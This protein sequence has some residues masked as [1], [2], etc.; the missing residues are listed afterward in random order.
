ME[1]RFDGKIALVTGAGKG[2]FIINNFKT[3]YDHHF[4]NPLASTTTTPFTET[5]VHLLNNSETS[6]IM[7]ISQ[8]HL[9]CSNCTISEHY[10]LY[11]VSQ[12]DFRD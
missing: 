12:F 4:S 10:V 8:G 1:F 9:E 5:N 6:S 11:F 3:V 2:M 7:L